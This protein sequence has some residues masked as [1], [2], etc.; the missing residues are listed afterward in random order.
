[1]KVCLLTDQ[2]LEAG[3]PLPDDDW[4]CDP[5]PFLPDAEWTVACLEKATAVQQ[6]IER[7]REGFD[8]FFNLCDG[9]WD[10]DT[11]GIEVVQTLERLELPFT[12]ATTEFYEPSREAMKRVCR[13]WGIDTPAY[14]I[15]S[16]ERDLERAAETLRFPLIVKHPSSYASVDL[17]RE[18]R[19]ETPKALLAR[20]RWMLKRHAGAL[21]EEFVEGI[22][23]TVLVAENPDDPERPTTYTP[24][25]YR[26]PEG[27]SFKH[28][29]MKWVTYHD[30]KTLPVDDPVLDERLR[31]VSSRLFVGLNG[32][33]YGRCDLRV[34]AEGRPFMLEINPN[35]G[36]YYPPEDP[37]SADLCLQLDPAGHEGFTRQ[38][39]EAALRRHERRIRKWEVRPWDGTEYGVF[40]TRRIRKGE[41]IMTFEEQP[42]ELAT[43]THVEA[44]WSEPRLSW[45]QR[46]AWPLSDEV[47]VMWSRDPEEWRPVNH[48]CEPTAWL[49]GL[50]VVARRA[51]RPGDEITLD[52]AT[53]CNEVMPSFSC[54]C[55][56]PNCRGTI[57]G[58][59]YLQ[60]FVGRYGEHVSDYVRRKR[61]GLERTEVPLRKRA[62]GRRGAVG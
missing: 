24:L 8:L 30:M 5:R 23:C 57:R 53:F 61:E 19:V 37:G 20:G 51:L 55:G 18:S 56:A 6:I 1:M 33:S 45:F 12:G 58:D 41:R 54:D 50:D 35:C 42:H 34:D 32:A 38:I 26:F 47:W 10:E 46:Y 62:A 59:D 44:K 9:A 17:I 4:P 2:D 3:L 16:S 39:V 11:A 15:A 29:D 22:E 13:A 14:V 60:D 36:L 40:A 21:I 25:Q 28:S 7:S 49:A 52:Y 48:A 31:E 27:E 43:R